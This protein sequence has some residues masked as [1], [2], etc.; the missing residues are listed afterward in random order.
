MFV[1]PQVK[2]LTCTITIWH[3]NNPQIQM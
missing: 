1:E 2:M 3:E